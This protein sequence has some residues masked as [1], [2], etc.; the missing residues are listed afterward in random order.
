MSQRTLEDLRVHRSKLETVRSELR[1]QI[2]IYEQLLKEIE[3]RQRAN[4]KEHS[5]LGE[6]A[7]IGA[8]CDRLRFNLAET[9]TQIA[10]VDLVSITPLSKECSEKEASMDGQRI[11]SQ[12]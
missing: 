8:L 10:I 11:N 5:L 9:E 7:M 3:G 4:A 2:V 6:R 12:F 1:D